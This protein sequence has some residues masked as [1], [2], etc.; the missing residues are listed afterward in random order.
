M[1][2]KMDGAHKLIQEDLTRLLNKCESIELRWKEVG[3]AARDSQQQDNTHPAYQTVQDQLPPNI[4]DQVLSNSQAEL[5]RTS[6]NHEQLK[7]KI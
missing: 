3:A 1:S 4:D 5:S 6:S 7:R 2:H